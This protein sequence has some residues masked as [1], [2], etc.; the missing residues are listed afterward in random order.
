MKI[1]RIQTAEQAGGPSE[2]EILQK[3]F[4]GLSPELQEL[5]VRAGH[6]EALM[7]DKA[8]TA[9]KRKELLKKGINPDQKTLN[10]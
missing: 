9:D 3:D 7:I 5:L 4:N 6:K 2:G 1:E 10:L 8:R